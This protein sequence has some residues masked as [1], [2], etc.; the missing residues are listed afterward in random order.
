MAAFLSIV[1]PAYNEAD[2]LPTTL[3]DL[4]EFLRQQAY[5]A[6]IV[7]VDDGSR[8]TTAAVV[9][10]AAH[11]DSRIH[12]IASTHRGKGAAVRQGMLAARADVRVMC[13]A[14]LS[15][16]PTEVPKLLAALAQG[17]DV[18]LATREGAGARRIA[19][20]F[21]RHLMGRAFNLLV[22]ALAVPDL[23]DTQCGFKA[24][25]AS[26]ARTLFGQATVDGFGFDV[27]VLYLARKYGLR[28]QEIPIVWYYQS[29]SR[30]SPLRDTLRMVHDLLRVRWND[31]RG[32]YM[33]PSATV[34]SGR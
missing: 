24:F 11:A 22:R 31:W 25:T 26:A 7:V 5:G 33:L 18:A 10:A 17:A 34:V 1:I 29:S 27:E 23:Q 19:E 4:G 32:R 14:D 21:H 3:R 28:L 2:R 8:D 9:Q 13:D 20:P 16:P 12:L 15:M 6:E 30:V